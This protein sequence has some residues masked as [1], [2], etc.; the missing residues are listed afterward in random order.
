MSNHHLAIWEFQVKPESISAFE[1]TYGPDAAW[2]QLFRQS[3][4]YLGTQLLRNLDH[5]GRYVTLDHWAARESLHH[6]KQDHQSAYNALDKL[7]ESLT[8]KE[9]FLGDLENV[10][11]AET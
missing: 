11:D 6:F 1:E 10:A 7:C 2:A 5:P 3:P 8:E 9:A 4:D